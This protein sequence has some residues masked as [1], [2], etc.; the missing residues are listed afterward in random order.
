[1]PDRGVFPSAAAVRGGPVQ[2]GDPERVAPSLSVQLL[3]IR[4]CRYLQNGLVPSRCLRR[5]PWTPSIPLSSLMTPGSPS[6]QPPLAS[7]PLQPRPGGSPWVQRSLSASP[8]RCPRAG[9]RPQ[10][11]P[12]ST[13]SP[14]MQQHCS[15]M[16]RGPRL[17]RSLSPL[18]GSFLTPSHLCSSSAAPGGIVGPAPAQPRESAPA[19]ILFSGTGRV[20]LGNG[21]AFMKV[22]TAGA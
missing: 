13:L 6:P 16:P 18:Q 14:W 8:G 11:H 17:E 21:A 12:H 7:P 20:R 10:R 5:T 3:V 4:S 9:A 19:A 22:L 15:C 2:I 1:M